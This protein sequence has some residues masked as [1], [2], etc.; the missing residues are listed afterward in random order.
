MV[1][2]LH[3]LKYH[4]ARSGDEGVKEG[5]ELLVWGCCC[6]CGCPSEGS[7]AL[8]GSVCPRPTL[9]QL[10]QHCW[11]GLGRQLCLASSASQGRNCQI[12][13][14]NGSFMVLQQ[15]PFAGGTATSKYLCFHK[16]VLAK[17]SALPSLPGVFPR[18]CHRSLGSGA[19]AAGCISLR[20]CD[21]NEV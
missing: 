4:R 19:G 18:C 21:S 1:S 14:F 3:L 5:S 8:G 2:L 17:R 9:R 12:K 16:H 15:E 7:W 6:R 13:S 20:G 11:R 10:L